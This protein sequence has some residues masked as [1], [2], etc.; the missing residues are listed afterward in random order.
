MSVPTH[1]G[2]QDDTAL[3]D[4]LRRI[5]MLETK[6]ATLERRPMVAAVAAP[7]PP[8]AP[9][10]VV[11]GARIMHPHTK[12][13]IALPDAKQRAA[14]AELVISTHK[15]LGPDA[16]SARWDDSNV[17]EWAREFEA[18]LMAVAAFGRGEID[19]KV[20]P[21][22][23]IDRAEDLLRA[24]PIAPTATV[25]LAPF[26]AACLSFGVAHTLNPGRYPHDISLGLT[27]VGTGRAAS[28]ADW[29]S[30]L[31]SRHLPDPVPMPGARPWS[32]VDG[33][34]SVTG[35]NAAVGL[36]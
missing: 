13:A 32:P 6:V 22:V 15:F 25:T 14:L 17:A 8:A 26:M 23:W 31:R 34:V 2:R 35:G 20:Y 19:T 11:E 4:A 12:V 21:S 30:V 18:S 7:P 29:Q 5:A 36:R 10:K 27:L 1:P 3:A 33:R 9:P 28:A 24:Q 16:S